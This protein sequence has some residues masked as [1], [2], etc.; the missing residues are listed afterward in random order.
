MLAIRYAASRN[1]DRLVEGTSNASHF[2]PELRNQTYMESEP[3][4][5]KLYFK[6]LL[7]IA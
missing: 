7:I 1:A 4:L 6:W 5:R 3:N 2:K